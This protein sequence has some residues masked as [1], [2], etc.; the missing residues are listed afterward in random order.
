MNGVRF[1]QQ[2]IK[3]QIKK[4]LNFTQWPHIP[5]DINRRSFLLTDHFWGYV[6]IE[7]TLFKI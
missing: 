2:I 5:N 1:E 3:R 4:S 6:H 7:N